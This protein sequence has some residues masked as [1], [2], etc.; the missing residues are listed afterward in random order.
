[1]RPSGPQA[2]RV[3]DMKVAPERGI[4]EQDRTLRQAASQELF[5]STPVDPTRPRSPAETADYVVGGRE[6]SPSSTTPSRSREFDFMLSNPP[7][8]GSAVARSGSESNWTTCEC[9]N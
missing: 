1:M 9:C 4:V 2:R 5:E 7:F 8:G 3:V 6:H